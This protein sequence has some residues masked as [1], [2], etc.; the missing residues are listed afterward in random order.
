MTMMN[1][2]L[3]IDDKYTISR[4][5][6]VTQSHLDPLSKDNKEYIN[7]ILGF[8]MDLHFTATF[9][10]TPEEWNFKLTS[11]R[12]LFPLHLVAW[13]MKL[14]NEEI[15]KAI[16]MWIELGFDVN[17]N[18]HNGATPLFVC[19]QVGN[20]NAARVLLANGADFNKACNNNMTLLISSIF[21]NHAD[22][23]D[24]IMSQKVDLSVKSPFGTAE[25]FCSQMPLLMPAF[26]EAK[27]KYYM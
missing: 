11:R 14:N 23:M 18:L 3:N 21:N 15:E 10:D 17:E 22:F 6:P 2:T 8:N 27:N 26:I 25:N 1:I 13:N 7:K 20:I 16:Q 24:F 5:I 9:C 12:Q 19:S 4:K